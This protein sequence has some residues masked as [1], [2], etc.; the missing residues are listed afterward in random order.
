MEKVDLQ[1]QIATKNGKLK[2]Q[3]LLVFC[4]YSCEIELSLDEADNKVKCHSRIH[5]IRI[6]K[7]WLF[8]YFPSSFLLCYT[9]E[10]QLPLNE[11]KNTFQIFFRVQRPR[12]AIDWLLTSQFQD[13]VHC[14]YTPILNK[15][16]FLFFPSYHCCVQ[17]MFLIKIRI[18]E[19]P[20]GAVDC[21]HACQLTRHVFK[22]K[23][24]IFKSAY[25]LPGQSD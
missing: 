22:S 8:S 14:F 11:G 5:R 17:H 6:I 19:S 3:V 15:V 16:I 1:K 4:F 12:I 20:G 7:G 13:L 21:I 9:Q 10:I 23:A 2:Q 25:L 24:T 18:F